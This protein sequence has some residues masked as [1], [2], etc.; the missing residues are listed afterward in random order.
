VGIL[1]DMQMPCKRVSLSIGALLGKL[2][3]VRWLGIFRRKEMCNWFPFLDPEDINILSL[4]ASGNLVK[5]Q[6][7]Q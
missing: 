1:R 7:S 4:S 2:E 5:E 3:G 6:G